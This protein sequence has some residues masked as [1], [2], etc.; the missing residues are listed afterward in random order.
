MENGKI[1]KC[2]IPA[3]SAFDLQIKYTET[4]RQSHRHEI[5]THTHKEFEL[6]INL[7][8]DVSFLVEDVLYPLSRGDVILAR[9][10]EHHHCVYRSDAPH[11]LFW[12]LF[13]CRGNEG[14]LDFLQSGF[15][16]NFVSPSAEHREELIGLCRALHGSELSDEAR[17]YSFLRIFA[18][19]KESRG[20]EKGCLRLP[21]GLAE[22]VEYIGAH[23]TE[24]LSVAELARRFYLSQSTLQRRFKEALDITPLEFIRQRRLRL[25]AALLREGASVLTAGTSVGFADNSYFIELF[26][27]YYGVTPFRYRQ[28]SSKE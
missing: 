5:W 26:R 13:D 6:Y 7:A 12:I 25:A 18:I 17:L 2:R 19:L 15:T 27:H 24:E 1:T 10:G 20:E 23:I 22:I 11:R 4:D 21:D 28:T 14:L 16:E 8:G 9:P 3:L